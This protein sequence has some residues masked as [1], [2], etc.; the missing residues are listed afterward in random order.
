VLYLNYE[1]ED[2]E[3]SLCTLLETDS[4]ETESEESQSEEN[5]GSE[6]ESSSGCGASYSVFLIYSDL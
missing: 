1:I 3:S 6:V 5:A 4:E 2:R